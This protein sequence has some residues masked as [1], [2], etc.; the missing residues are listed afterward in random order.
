[1][2]L[3]LLF[4]AY[5]PLH[6]K[7][8][9]FFDNSFNATQWSTLACSAVN[10]FGDA[11][12]RFQPSAAPPTWDNGR[13]PNADLQNRLYSI[14]EE[15][16][17]DKEQEDIETLLQPSHVPTTRQNLTLTALTVRSQRKPASR[18]LKKS[19]RSSTNS[20]S[21]ITCAR[22]HSSR[23]KTSKTAAAYP[24]HTNDHLHPANSA[25]LSPLI[26]PTEQH[27]LAP[28]PTLLRETR[29]HRTI[30]SK[31]SIAHD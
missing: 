12:V 20:K 22:T 1:V 15:L 4:R 5:T 21:T 3:I 14:Q 6:D 27:S 28:A 13:V 26:H 9:S 11:T 8:C 24:H 25:L 10:T 17:I 23:A 7:S 19:R 18:G 2:A 30:L 29:E 16:A 31:S